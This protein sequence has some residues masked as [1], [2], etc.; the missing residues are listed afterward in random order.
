MLSGSIFFNRYNFM[1]AIYILYNVINNLQHVVD[2]VVPTKQNNVQT[3]KVTSVYCTYLYYLNKFILIGRWYIRR[4]SAD[5]HLNVVK[6]KSQV[7]LIKRI[8]FNTKSK[9]K[10]NRS[11]S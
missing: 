7:F 9:L 8:I 2:L 3:D 6:L 10:I 1:C 5:K 4:A 11:L